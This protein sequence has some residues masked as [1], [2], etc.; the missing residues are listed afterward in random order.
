MIYLIILIVVFLSVLNVLCKYAPVL[1]ASETERKYIKYK[2]KY[3]HIFVIDYA[4]VC[5]FVFASV[6]F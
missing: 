6:Y 4:C 5:V 2:I 3:P 1:A